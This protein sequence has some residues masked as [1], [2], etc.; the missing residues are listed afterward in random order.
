VT[1]RVRFAPS[2]TGLLH[3]GNARIAVFNWLFARAN[4][5]SF[6]LRIEDTDRE[7]NEGTE[8]EIIR[9]LDWLG[10]DRDEGPGI[11]GAHG[12]YRQSLRRHIHEFALQALVDSG[13]A[14]PCFCQKGEGMRE[15]RYSGRC[16]E[17]GKA[18]MQRM[19]EGASCAIRL[20][21]PRRGEVTVSDEVLG[22]ISFPAADIDDFVIRRRNGSFTYNFAAAVDDIHMKITHVIRGSG[23]VSNTP[24]Q[25][26][27]FRALGREEPAFAHLPTVLAPDGQKRSKRH[28]AQ[29]LGSLRTRGYPPD[30]VL[31]YVSLLGWSHPQEQEVLTRSELIGAIGLNRVGRT[32]VRFDSSKLNWVSARHIAAEKLEDL[33]LNLSEFASDKWPRPG[34]RE[35]LGTVLVL[36]SRLASYGEV[37][38]H[39]PLLYPREASPEAQELHPYARL[40]LETVRKAI[41][42]DPAWELPGPEE[43]AVALTAAVRAAGKRVGV[44]G[45]R[46]LFHPLR[47]A[48]ISRKKGPDI[49][50]LLVALGQQES[51]RRLDRALGRNARQP[52]GRS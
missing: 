11:G 16:R 35:W 45:P 2:P 28:G 44:N 52:D 43:L 23:H 9:D 13:A 7:R 25:A 30:A 3:I 10:L 15:H 8:V 34:E 20:A 48:L 18:G 38:D 5:G 39:L 42:S 33:A 4:G 51:L 21:S 47:R 1:V 14:Y 24:R 41:A 27:V 37:D 19:V 36:R 17:L 49:G 29:P 50:Q 26:L 32:A 12:P 22:E 6:I 46:F 40:G 31:N